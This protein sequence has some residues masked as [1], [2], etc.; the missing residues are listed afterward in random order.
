MPSLS[1]R[2]SSRS[3]LGHKKPPVSPRSARLVV[4]CLGEVLGS[5]MLMYFGCM[6]L[7]SGFSQAPLPGMQ[8]GLMFGFVVSTIIVIFGHISGAHLN[9]T[10]SLSAYLLDMIPLIELPV[11]FVSQIV[12][13]LI[14]VGLLHVVTPQ[15]ILYPLGGSVGFCV[16]VPHASLTQAQAFLAEFL[17]TSLLIFTCCGVWDPRNAR[18]GDA[19]PIKFALVIALCSITVGP[20]TGAS[21]NPAR[22]LAPAVFSQVWTAHWLYW[23]AP[24][25]ASLVSTLTYKYLFSAADSLLAGKSHSTELSEGDVEGSVP[26]PIN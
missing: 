8:G 3:S 11:Y 18:H 15:E 2:S 7:V 22:S 1:L 13:C 14:G 24:M 12:G 9:P 6:S 19:T 26:M 25:L 16:T 23:V 20:Y 4:L 5:A 10:V 17:S 21:M